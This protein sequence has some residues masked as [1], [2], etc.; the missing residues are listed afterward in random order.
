MKKLG[1][2]KTNNIIKKLIENKLTKIEIKAL[3]ELVNGNVIKT[4]DDVLDIIKGDD[5]FDESF[6]IRNI[7]GELDVGKIKK[8]KGWFLYE[9]D[10]IKSLNRFKKIKEEESKWN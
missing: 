7:S 10:I 4:I 9:K 6:I 2:E 8:E 3:V 5:E 1:V